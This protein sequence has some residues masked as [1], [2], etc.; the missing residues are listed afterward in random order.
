MNLLF[1]ITAMSCTP[2]SA[3]GSRPALSR[4]KKEI[5]EAFFEHTRYF[6]TQLRR[7][8]TKDRRGYSN[9]Y[10]LYDLQTHLQNAA[11]YADEQGNRE[12][13]A[14][15][16]ALCKIP[17]DSQYLTNG[18]WLNNSNGLI[19]V[20]VNLVLAQYFSL[21][22]RVL[23]ACERNGIK[24]NFTDENIRIVTDHINHWLAK[25]V[26]RN[27]V[28]DRHLFFVQ[29]VLQFHD[30]ST[31]IDMPIQRLDSW[32]KYV[33]DYMEKSIAPKWE[34][35][36]FMYRGEKYDCLALDRTGWASYVD[37]AYAG[38]GSE[39]TK[40]KSDTDP[41]AMFTA[42]GTVKQPKK[43][44]SKVG[45]DISHARRFNW[46]FE[47]V[48]RFGKPFGVSISDEILQGWANNLAFLVCRGSLKKPH[49]TIFSD[50]VDGWFRVGYAG[51]RGFGYTLGDM[52]LAFVASSYGFFGVYN[53]KIYAWMNAWVKANYKNGLSGYHGAYQLDYLT[54][55]AIDIRKPLAHRSRNP[56]HAEP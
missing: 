47:T 30:Y 37:F 26:N 31:Q 7:D 10:V 23:S 41:K 43:P 44:V 9:T 51:R 49:F 5:Q 36:I 24:T 22:T 21:L 53:A 32:K 35:R 27:R 50:G 56:F 13:L 3:R 14:V 20:E 2:L 55:M 39:I 19:G 45:T 54:S 15:L 16:L 11:I 12:M 52:D 18:K 33:R 34:K 29:S 28:D 6:K 17:F 48:K 38:Y 46:F 42:D 25:P 8:L 40:T 1:I 4:H